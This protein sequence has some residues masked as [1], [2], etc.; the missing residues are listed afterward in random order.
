MT[1]SRGD[2]YATVALL[3][4]AGVQAPVRPFST[5]PSVGNKKVAHLRARFGVERIV[6]AR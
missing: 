1:G 2:Y 6:T 4:D 3:G 5:T